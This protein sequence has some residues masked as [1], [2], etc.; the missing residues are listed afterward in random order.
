MGMFDTIIAEIECPEC[1]QT[2]EREIQTK[3]GP[4][5]METY[6]L[7]DTIEPFFFGDYWFEEEWYCGDCQR[8]AREKDENAKIDWRKVYV[9]CING[10]IVGI[11]NARREEEK[12]PDWTLIRRISR[13]RHNYRNLLLKIDGT[14]RNFRGRKDGE[15]H[16]PFDIGPKTTDELFE[17]IQEDIGEVLKGKSL[18][19][20]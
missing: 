14:I 6:H 18:G 4:C 3:R 17:R 1:R 13:D 5:L 16:F 19:F 12:L 8:R 10:L 20:F 2:K 11:S 7:G 9:H 15:A